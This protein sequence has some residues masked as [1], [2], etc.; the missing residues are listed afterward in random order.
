[1]NSNESI[2]YRKLNENWMKIE[3]KLNE[4]WMKIWILMEFEFI[5]IESKFEFSLSY[6][7]LTDLGLNFIKNNYKIQ[8]AL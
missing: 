8:F 6:L 2:F 5:G 7:N 4:N 1:L 3:W